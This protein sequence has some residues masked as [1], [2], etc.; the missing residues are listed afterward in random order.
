MTSFLTLDDLSLQNKT[1]LV[2]ADLNV[3]LKDGNILDETRIERAAK[4]L[5]EIHRKGGKSILI[6]HLGR[7]KGEDP[8]SL[9]LHQLMPTLEKATGLKVTFVSESRGKQVEEA[10]K[11]HQTGYILLLENLRFHKE[12]EGNDPAFAE[13]LARLADIYVNDGF[14]VS[15][16]AHASV[17]GV[18]R[19]LP[20]FAGRLMEE[21]LT[22]LQKG[23][24]HPRRPLFA[25]VAGAK[26]S[27]KLTL[28]ENLLTRVDGLILGGGIANTFLKA[29]GKEIG[30]SL[31]EPDMIET[32]RKILEKATSLSK[33]ILLPTDSMGS[34]SLE[35]SGEI[36]SLE[37]VTADF[38]IFDAGPRSIKAY[39]EALSHVKT[40]VWNG[41]LGV[42]EIPPYDQGTLR[43]ARFVANR[44]KE[45]TLYAVA[46][47]GETVAALHKAGSADGF[48]YVSS[49]GGAFL[50]WLE[51]KELPGV[52]ALTR[53][54]E[55]YRKSIKD[56]ENK[57]SAPN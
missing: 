10:A 43:L 39:E 40:L 20:S 5:M 3:P 6:S 4:T 36:R 28:I 2:R 25:I 29:Q 26:V 17:E 57:R 11:K 7:P 54:A 21:E 16:R 31:Y 18:T 8:S 22:A 44:V 51:G 37:E 55:T 49:A 47:G 23:L 32:A 24:E 14:S 33:E 41:P 1:V 38:K 34:T 30:G 15:H 53:S 45:G 27:T 12:E 50:E 48:S 52:A 35:A 19:F 46:G 9:S 42:F 56:L 13:D